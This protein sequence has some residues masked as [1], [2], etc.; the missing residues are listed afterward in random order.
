[1]LFLNQPKK[2][3]GEHWCADLSKEQEVS[4]LYQPIVRSFLKLYNFTLDQTLPPKCYYKCPSWTTLLSVACYLFCIAG[5][6]TWPVAQLLN[7][8]SE[9]LS[10]LSWCTAACKQREL[11]CESVLGIRAA[12]GTHLGWMTLFC[13][14]IPL[15]PAVS[16]PL[17]SLIC[18]QVVPEEGKERERNGWALPNPG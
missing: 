1:M 11:H 3:Q 8:C 2:C 4:I 10:L 12:P 7:V 16:T 5:A 13:R 15:L 14:G 17:L 6:C 18:P 9:G